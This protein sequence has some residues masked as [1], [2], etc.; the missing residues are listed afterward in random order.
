MPRGN[1]IPSADA[2]LGC[3]TSVAGEI[4]SR[5]IP[6]KATKKHDNPHSSRAATHAHPLLYPTVLPSMLATR[7]GHRIAAKR[8]HLPA[9]LLALYIHVA[10]RR[11]RRRRAKAAAVRSAAASRASAATRAEKAD[12]EAEIAEDSCSRVGCEAA[13]RASN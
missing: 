9:S 8:A 5:T 4:A 6:Q 13:I 2:D 1:A 7:A 3:N 12:A 11:Q 10:P